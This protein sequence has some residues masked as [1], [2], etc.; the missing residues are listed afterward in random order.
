MIVVTGA[1]G[2]LGRRIV[3]GL[4]RRVDAARVT[5]VTRTP[6]KIADLGVRTRQAGFGDL[7]QALDGAE[8]LLLMSLPH[9]P[10]RLHLHNEAI[11]GAV[12]AGIGHIVYAS[13]TRAGDPGNPV[14]VVADHGATER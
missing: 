3:E 11:R 6:D 13:V 12:R 10:D 9:S 14:N 5:A 1:S 2:N 8:R 4:V 7:A